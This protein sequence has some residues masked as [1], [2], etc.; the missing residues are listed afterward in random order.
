LAKMAQP[1]KSGRV[2]MGACLAW[3]PL[4]VLSQF[5]WRVGCVALG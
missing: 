1:S 2:D 3:H 4:S 5:A